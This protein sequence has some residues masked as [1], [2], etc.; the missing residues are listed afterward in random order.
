MTTGKQGPAGL[1]DGCLEMEKT[2]M[3]VLS[4]QL[5]PFETPVRNCYEAGVQA[6]TLPG[7]RHKAKDIQLAALFLKRTLTDLRGVWLFTHLGYTSQAASV[8]AAL[9][10]HALVVNYLAGSANHAMELL[11]N[12]TGDLP[13]SVAQLSKALSRQYNLEVDRWQKESRHKSD[14]REIYAAYKF[15]CKIKHPTLRSTMHDAFSAAV[16]DGEF[17]VMAAPDVREEDL[18][19]KATILAISIS[20]CYQAVRQFAI[21]LECDNHSEYYKSFVGRMS[22]IIPDTVK[23][24]NLLTANKSLPFTIHDGDL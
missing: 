6:P 10:E 23:A 5:A 7:K 1:W 21:A 17:V 20:R 24:Y 2:A 12:K 18:P 15:L 8:A 3:R 14:W 4:A 9:Y 11:R 13:W 22:S 19:L 16:K